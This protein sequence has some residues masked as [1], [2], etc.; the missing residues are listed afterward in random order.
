MSNDF[1][2]FHSIVN[3]DIFHEDYR[4]FQHNNIFDFSQKNIIVLY[5]P[6]GTG[7]TSL[8]RCLDIEDV[9]NSD[10]KV[11]YSYN[12]K[13]YYD[14]SV[15]LCVKDQLRRNVI[16]G[17]ANDYLLG[18][19]IRKEVELKTFIDKEYPNIVDSLRKVF[20]DYG[21]TT[22]DQPLKLF[23]AFEDSIPNL[24]SN[25]ANSRKKD[26]I[27][28]VDLYD[29][30]CKVYSLDETISEEKCNLF[31]DKELIAVYQKVLDVEEILRNDRVLEIEEN[32]SAIQILEKYKSKTQCIVCDTEG[33]NSEELLSK[34]QNNKSRIMRLL[35]P[36]TQKLL[37]DVLSKI[38]DSD[39]FGLKQILTEAIRTGE[40]GPF[41]KVQDEIRLVYKQFCFRILNELADILIPSSLGEKYKEYQALISN[42][43][44]LQDEDMSFIESFM[45]SCVSNQLIINRDT[46]QNLIIKLGDEKVLGN[47]KL[48]LSTGELNFLSLCFELL[49][50]RK[51]TKD[52][53]V[54]DDPISSFDSIYKNKM[55]YA[56]VSFLQSK[57]TI[58]MTHNFDVFRLLN[59]QYTN[60]CLLY[61]FNNVEGGD[62]G[63]IPV[64][65]DESKLVVDL[66]KLLDLFRANS[67]KPDGK[68]S[69]Q[70]L[71]I[72]MIPFMRG[73]A[74]LIG[75]NIMKVNLTRVMHGYKN[76]KV[77]IGSIYNQLFNIRKNKYDDYVLSVSDILNHAIP[78]DILDKERFP[79]LNKTLSTSFS[80][81]YLRLLVEKTLV[82]CCNVSPSDS[83]RGDKE[84]GTLIKEAFPLGAKGSDKKI[85][86]CRIFLTS[87]K[88]LL[89]EFNHFEGN[90]SIFQPAMDI[91][92][93]ALQKEKKE[94]IEF[95][96]DL[97]KGSSK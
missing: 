97:H 13:K 47:E 88:T 29:K 2:E 51:S 18:E 66:V 70:N 15:F 25:L 48:K 35:A 44:E 92:T 22:K 85:A 38:G 54:I 86:D 31:K 23:D 62:N 20:K 94:I 6:N 21:I 16:E 75:K 73:Y 27:T 39:L 10:L 42:K 3:G 74:G 24:L 50:V 41:R 30:F 78:I 55:I 63:F 9:D 64:N 80:Y 71:L 36:E 26:P 17:N 77:N 19:N 7:K 45:N 56:I 58:I 67:F 28:I 8:L 34:K 68:L 76:D 12:K 11:E 90:L 14:G 49:K 53:V 57:K 79:L 81:L 59:A 69:Q 95:C 5:G 89:N 40:L 52:I 87:K 43:F 84:L 1:L 83:K 93:S 91:S 82:E 60:C 61:L 37:A 33:I 72:A 32:D 46:N 96:E 65:K 4:E